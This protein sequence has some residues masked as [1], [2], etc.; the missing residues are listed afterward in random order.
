[1]TKKRRHITRDEQ[2]VIDILTKPA[3]RIVRRRQTPSRP[4]DSGRPK[5][6]RRPK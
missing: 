1:M 6:S 5:S 2:S 3:G 4:Q